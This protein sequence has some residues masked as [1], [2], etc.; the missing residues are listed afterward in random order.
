MNITID[1]DIFSNNNL[2]IR[3]G[4]ECILE[5]KVTDNMII[6]YNVNGPTRNKDIDLTG[7]QNLKFVG[8]DIYV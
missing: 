3:Y 8:V 1:V 4:D 6:L 5:F 2:I 7:N